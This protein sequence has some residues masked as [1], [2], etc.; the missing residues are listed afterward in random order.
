[1]LCAIRQ[2]FNVLN[3]LKKWLNLEK[4]SSHLVTLRSLCRYVAAKRV[5]IMQMS[6]FQKLQTFTVAYYTLPSVK[7]NRAQ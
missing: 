5:K 7:L 2:I 3:F 1:M 6:N 4:L